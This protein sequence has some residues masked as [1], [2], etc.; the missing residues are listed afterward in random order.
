MII[1]RNIIPHLFAYSLSYV[2][3]TLVV[4]YILN[5]PGW[6]TESYDL[7]REYYIKNGFKAFVLDWFLVAA[8]ILVGLF[9]IKSFHKEKSQN[10]Q[11][12]AIV[13]GTSFFISFLFMIL[14]KTRNLLPN[15][16][17]SRWF[18]KVGTLA[19]VYDLIIVSCVYFLY[20]K[21]LC[22]F[23]YHNLI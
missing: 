12:F 2:L 1:M 13:A 16:F 4:V 17:F 20:Q 8:Y 7:V 6:L 10:Y 22:K 11:K 14:F 15:T 3:V 9:L 23:K 18:H 5:F 21:L 19:A